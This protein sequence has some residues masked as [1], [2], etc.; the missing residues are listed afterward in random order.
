MSLP[1]APWR[2]AAIMLAAALPVLI[3]C[4]PEPAADAGA[5]ASVAT[6]DLSQTLAGIR[7]DLA[8]RNY[9]SAAAKAK[10][11]QVA[12]PGEPEV[13]LVAA[14]SE[15][16][17]GNAGNAAAA[18]QRAMDSGL[19]DPA[20]ALA[21]AAFNGVRGSEP[22][23]RLRRDLAAGRQ[24]TSAAGSSTAEG[25]RIRAG[26]VEIIADEAGDYVRAGDVVLDLRK[27]N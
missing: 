9:G 22:F 2:M 15:A 7:L 5:G 26:D 21:S 6:P 13:H 10:T 3:A 25:D 19:T 14:Q 27:Q 12:F 16:L 24:P 23:A 18:F 20:S 8:E 4:S 1:A 17:L 11:A